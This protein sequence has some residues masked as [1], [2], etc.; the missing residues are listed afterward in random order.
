MTGLTAGGFLSLTAFQ[1]EG[2]GGGFAADYKVSVTGLAFYII[3]HEKHSADWLA[4]LASPYPAS[5]DFPRK[6]GEE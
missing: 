4:A 2:C 6:R 3:W 5:P 1:A